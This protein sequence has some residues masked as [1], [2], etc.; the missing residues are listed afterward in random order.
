MNEK[1]SA[2]E[3]YKLIDNLLTKNANPTKEFIAKKCGVSVKAI[4]KDFDKMR[5]D[6]QL[7][8]HAPIV[9]NPKG[10]T[11][12]YADPNFSI[13]KSTDLRLLKDFNLVIS[14]GSTIE[15][16]IKIALC[17]NSS[18]FVFSSFNSAIVILK[19]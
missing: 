4:E 11:Y 2:L 9:H 7:N 15:F 8:F 16:S 5:N 12:Y 13:N 19:N 17:N 10:N 14:S 18:S 1:K 3:R 6:N